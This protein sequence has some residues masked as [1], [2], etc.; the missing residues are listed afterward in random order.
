M[1]VMVECGCGKTFDETRGSRYKRCPACALRAKELAQARWRERQRAEKAPLQ[2]AV[3]RHVTNLTVV[4]DPL[5]EE[6]GFRAGVVFPKQDWTLMLQY[7]AFTPGTILR[8]AQM[9]L[10]EFRLGEQ[11]EYL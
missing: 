10:Y 3:A 7:L 2:A 5:E 4:C 1:G 9:R 6:G 11:Q 8:D